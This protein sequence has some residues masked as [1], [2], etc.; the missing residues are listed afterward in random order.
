[1][2]KMYAEPQLLFV[3][4]SNED[5]ITCSITSQVQNEGADI[6]EVNVGNLFS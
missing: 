3:A 1:M 4:V 6:K 5:T 2:K